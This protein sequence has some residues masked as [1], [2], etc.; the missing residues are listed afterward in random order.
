MDK[1]PCCDLMNDLLLRITNLKTVIGCGASPLRVVDG[2]DLEIRRGETFT[3]LGE[4][5]CGKSM[6][7]LS[8][9]RLLP[10]G[11]RI[12]DGSVELDGVNLLKLSEQEIKRSRGQPA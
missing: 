10:A 8:I 11:G 12:T 4:S 6:S 2:L 5:G 1:G 7:A 3:L 9:M